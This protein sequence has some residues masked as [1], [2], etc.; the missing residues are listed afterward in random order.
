M[1]GLQEYHETLTEMLALSGFKNGDKYF[2]SPDPNYQPPPPQED[3]KITLEREKMAAANAQ[4]EAD[5]QQDTLLR[6]A[7]INA[8]YNT[9]IDTAHIR[10]Q[11]E[12][13]RVVADLA[14]QESEA[15]NR[16]AKEPVT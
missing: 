12:Q 8:R 14:V 4:K 5:R 3:P 16:Y 2:R 10:A 9:S 6:L 13:L 15:R 1:V 11:A 7:E